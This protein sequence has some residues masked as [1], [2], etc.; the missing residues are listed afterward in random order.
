YAR[1]G[2]ASVGFLGP[3]GPEETAMPTGMVW[4]MIY[5]PER[6]DE[7]TLEAVTHEQLWERL[8]TFLEEIVPVAEEVDGRLA[9]HP[10]D[11]PMPTIRGKARLVYQP[12][13]YQKLL[14]V[15]PSRS[16]ALEF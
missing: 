11:P 2:A 15:K 3:D 10:D 8:T 14:D 12:H 6:L 5:A 13:Y 9:A 16:N 1:G 4:N 7:G